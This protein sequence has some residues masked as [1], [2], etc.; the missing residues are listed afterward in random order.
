VSKEPTEEITRNYDVCLSFAGEN[1]AYIDA[2]AN[3]LQIAGVRTF[4]DEFEKADLWGKD[5][6]AHLHDI[7]QNQ[8]TYCVMFISKYYVEKAW[9]SHERRSAQARAFESNTEYLLPVRF[10]DTEVPGLA[11]T[12]GFVDTRT[13]S[14]KELCEMIIKKI[15][16][17]PRV[18]YFPPVPD[19]LFKKLGARSNKD[20]QLIYSVSYRL[21]ESLSRLNTEERL[22]VYDIFIHACPA[23]LPENVHIDIDLLRRIS[24]MQPAKIKKLTSGIQ[25]LGFYQSIRDSH[26]PEDKND[27]SGPVLVLEWHNMSTVYNGN[28]T[29]LVSILIDCVTDLYCPEHARMMFERLDFGQLATSTTT[30]DEH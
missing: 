5:L 22:L 18:N 1:R 17:R 16:P 23:E 7:Y 30:S 11:D 10:D 15:G 14:Q 8:A 27:N 21:F 9:T 13:T 25:S 29:A 20:R 3:L 12:I 4:Y 2:L 24:G 26:D 28:F 19:R 6:Y